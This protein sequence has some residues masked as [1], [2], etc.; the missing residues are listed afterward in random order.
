MNNIWKYLIVGVLAFVLGSSAVVSAVVVEKR[1][2]TNGDGT[3]DV[4]VT[5]KGQLAMYATGKMRMTIVNPEAIQGP[6]GPTGSTGD[7]GDT[8]PTDPAGSTGDTQGPPGGLGTNYLMVGPDAFQPWSSTLGYYFNGPSPGVRIS[9]SS[10][11]L[12]APVFLPNGAEVTSMKAYIYDNQSAGDMTVRLY[13]QTM[14]PASNDLMAIVDSSGISF[15]GTST[16]STISEATI[17]NQN[18]SYM[19]EVSSSSW[20]TELIFVGVLITYTVS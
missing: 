13:S 19:V 2:L 7:T 10:G 3:R 12:L 9:D 1:G 11:G 17:D 18:R 14:A 15:E 8:G 6:T 5:Q 4:A 16:D 20:S